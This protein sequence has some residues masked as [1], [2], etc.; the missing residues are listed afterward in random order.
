MMTLQLPRPTPTPSLS[1]P[2]VVRIPLIIGPLAR[3]VVATTA[4]GLWLLGLALPTLAHTLRHE[5][6]ICPIDGHRFSEFVSASGTQWGSR[7]DNKPLGPIAAPWDLAQC[8]KC[9][10]V[11]ADTAYTPATLSQLK[12]VV[13]SEAYRSAASNGPTYYCLARL[14][15]LTGA[16]PRA[17]G[18]AYLKAS[19]QVEKDS[20]R[21]REYL[22]RALESFSVQLKSLK[23]EDRSW[24][25]LARLCGEL[26]R[27]LGQFDTAAAR[28]QNLK[29][30]EPSKP[31]HALID[32]QLHFIA[33]ADSA[34][35][36]T[37]ERLE[38][39]VTGRQPVR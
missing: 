11:L 24:A 38:H 17:V 18:D 35:H 29:T 15:E 6:F 10:F 32:R 28:L 27:R 26:E 22:M 13:P 33:Q 4:V 39:L 8:P 19:W 25:R 9:K 1:A 36:A 7:L 2:V 31:D 12:S 23:P 37:S 34:P 5:E 16:E 3:R 21:C 14:R 20:A 30:M